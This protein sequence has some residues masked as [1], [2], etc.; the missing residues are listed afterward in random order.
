MRPKLDKLLDELT[1]AQQQIRFQRAVIEG[2]A[3]TQ[4][5]ISSHHGWL[6]ALLKYEARVSREIT[7][8]ENC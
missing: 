4:Y 7:E 8:L 6:D 5:P 2:K 1:Y 3:P